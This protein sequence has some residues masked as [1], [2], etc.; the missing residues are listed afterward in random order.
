MSGYS[1][2]WGGMVLMLL[3]HGP[4]DRFTGGAR[5]GTHQLV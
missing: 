5:L 4:L 1:F 2:S 3:G